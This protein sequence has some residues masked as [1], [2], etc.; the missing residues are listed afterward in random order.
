MV[1]PLELLSME[2][3]HALRATMLPSIIWLPVLLDNIMPQSGLSTWF[4]LV[5]PKVLEWDRKKYTPYVASVSVLFASVESSV[6]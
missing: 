3:P 4:P 5:P 6:V 1:F 2:M